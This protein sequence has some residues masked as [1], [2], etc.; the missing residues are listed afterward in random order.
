MI[1][2]KQHPLQKQKNLHSINETYHTNNQYHTMKDEKKECFLA[3]FFVK[4]NA[5]H[6]WRCSKAL[7]SRKRLERES[8]EKPEQYPLL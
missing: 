2:I 8:G 7:S 5:L 1:V 4:N 3:L 6:L